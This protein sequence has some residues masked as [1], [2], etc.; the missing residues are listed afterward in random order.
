MSAWARKE[1]HPLVR[2]THLEDD[3]EG[4]FYQSKAVFLRNAF[5][6]WPEIPVNP[7]TFA[8]KPSNGVPFG[9]VP[10]TIGPKAVR[11]L[12]GL[13]HLISSNG[14]SKITTTVIIKK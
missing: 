14:F 13:S 2:V 4:S 8:K 11:P 7:I 12:I 3:D 9:T 10:V 1:R 5:E 6:K